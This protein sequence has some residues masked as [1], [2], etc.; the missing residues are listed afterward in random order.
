MRMLIPLS[1]IFFFNFV[2]A[3][4]A[5]TEVLTADRHDYDEV[6]TVLVCRATTQLS[7]GAVEIIHHPDESSLGYPH[8][9]WNY[10]LSTR[11]G[12]GMI[13]G[14]WPSVQYGG[15]YRE[16]AQVFMVM[17]PTISSPKIAR[18]ELHAQSNRFNHWGMRYGAASEKSADSSYYSSGIWHTAE[19]IEASGDK[20]FLRV[21][22]ITR[23]TINAN[24]YGN[25]IMNIELPKDLFATAGKE[26]EILLSDTKNLLATDQSS[27]TEEEL[28]EIVI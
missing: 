12:I 4:C 2:I 11:Q 8:I 16:R 1:I 25:T 22:R 28:L 3:G 6:D 27:C 21:Q 9:E 17:T 20:M 10:P 19:S 26:I 14:I 24:F 13:S 18:V 23:D 15:T 5:S 7:Y